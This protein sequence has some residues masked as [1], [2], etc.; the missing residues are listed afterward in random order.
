L[1]Q[2]WGK[3]TAI[4]STTISIHATAEEA[5]TEIEQLADRI[6]ATGDRPDAIALVVIGPDGRV[7]VRRSH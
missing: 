6:M 1:V 3:N 4:Q 5:F 7:V 2:P